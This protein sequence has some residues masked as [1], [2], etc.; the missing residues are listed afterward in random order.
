M[1]KDWH[2]QKYYSAAQSRGKK[3]LAST[4]SSLLAFSHSFDAV[5]LGFPPTEAGTAV[6]LDEIASGDQSQGL[7]GRS[8][9]CWEPSLTGSRL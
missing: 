8:I 5:Q 6:A 7:R 9:L 1:V 4:P 2:W 3:H